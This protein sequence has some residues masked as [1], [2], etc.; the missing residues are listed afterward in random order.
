M[1]I[2]AQ[3][4]HDVRVVRQRPVGQVRREL[5]ERHQPPNLRGVVH[6]VREQR[7]RIVLPGVIPDVPAGIPYVRQ[8]LRVRLPGPSGLEQLPDDVVVGHDRRV[9]VVVGDDLPDVHH[10]V[11]ADGRVGVRIVLRREP[12][13]L[14]QAVE[15][16]H[17]R[18][19]D[20]IRVVGVLLRDDEHVPEGHSSFCPAG[21]GVPSRPVRPAAAP[22]SP[23]HIALEPLRG[24]GVVRVPVRALSVAVHGLRPDRI[25]VSGEPC[26]YRGRPFPVHTQTGRGRRETARPGDWM[27][28]TGKGGGDLVCEAREKDIPRVARRHDRPPGLEQAVETRARVRSCGTVRDRSRWH[29]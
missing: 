19:A 1:P 7:E 28:P 27:D 22:R 11:V 25:V 18:A 17:R 4:G 26:V 24:P 21:S 5:R 29:R 16:R 8:V 15:I 3:I 14:R 13:L 6:D 20:H 10:E 9:V 12:V 2:V 23:G